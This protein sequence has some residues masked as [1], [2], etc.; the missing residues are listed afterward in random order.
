MKFA[1][2]GNMSTLLTSSHVDPYLSD[3]VTDP[4]K[5]GLSLSP[6]LPLTRP[7]YFNLNYALSL[8]LLNSRFLTKILTSVQANAVLFRV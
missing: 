6:T 8:S 7:V 4:N 3:R 2:S 1:K 5:T